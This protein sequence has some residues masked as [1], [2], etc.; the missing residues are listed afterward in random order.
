MMCKY[1]LTYLV[2][3]Q[4][5]LISVLPEYLLLTY[6]RVKLYWCM[7]Q[8]FIRWR[9][10]NLSRQTDDFII[11]N[12]LMCSNDRGA[13]FLKHTIANLSRNSLLFNHKNDLMKEKY[14]WFGCNAYLK[15]KRKAII[16]NVIGT[17]E[18]IKTNNQNFKFDKSKS[19]SCQGHKPENI[20]NKLKS[21]WKKNAI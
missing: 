10:A 15:S 14:F 5:S 9:R 3:I 20:K 4:V 16:N 6:S 7:Y 19:M 12:F 21:F 8:F 2:K 11:A 17:L 13:C 18:K 1:L